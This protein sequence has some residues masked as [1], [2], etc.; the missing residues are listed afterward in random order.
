MTMSNCNEFEL[1]FRFLKERGIK[2]E[3][4]TLKRTAKCAFCGFLCM[5]FV[6]L[7]VKCSI[8]KYNSTSLRMY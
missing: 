5:I 3:R 4:P 1:L 2:E 6:R 7:Q 8:L